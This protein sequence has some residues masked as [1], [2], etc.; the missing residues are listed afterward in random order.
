M[1]GRA[2]TIGILVRKLHACGNKFKSKKTTNK[3]YWGALLVC[4]IGTGD[5]LSSWETCLA[6]ILGKK[7]ESLLGKWK[8][9]VGYYSCEKLAQGDSPGK[10]LIILSIKLP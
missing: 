10:G 5:C 4:K 2:S 3:S 6:F 8:W 1:G 9:S 7:S